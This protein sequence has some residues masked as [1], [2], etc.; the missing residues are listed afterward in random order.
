MQDVS[1]IHVDLDALWHVLVK[2]NG[3]VHLGLNVCDDVDI[4]V[5]RCCDWRMRSRSSSAQTQ[6]RPD[7]VTH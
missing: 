4:S 5:S 2:L 7:H 6:G 1:Y 3:P